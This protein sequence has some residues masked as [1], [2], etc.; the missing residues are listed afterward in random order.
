M[1]PRSRRFFRLFAILPAAAALVLAADPTIGIWKLDVRKSKFLPGPGFQSE[2]RTYEER[3]DGVRVSIRTVDAKG[4]QATI[5]YLA[6]P[7]GQ[8]HPVSGAGGPADAVALKRINDYIA[9]S[10]LLHAG[11]EI[12]K[13]TRTVSVDGKKMTIVYDGLDPYGSRVNYTLVYDRVK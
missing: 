1:L 2:T 12:A 8:Q 13:T 10:T 7:D 9:E 3:K 5:V 11:R 4:K 6:T